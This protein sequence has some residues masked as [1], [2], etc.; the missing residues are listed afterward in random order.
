[1]SQIDREEV[2]ETDSQLEESKAG[3]NTREV[4]RG[5]VCKAETQTKQ[6]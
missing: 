1:M 6:H 3:H 5:V 4:Y 2:L